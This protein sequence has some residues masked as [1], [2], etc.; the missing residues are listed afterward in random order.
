[1]GEVLGHAAVAEKGEPPAGESTKHA[2]GRRR[3][4]LS[5]CGVLT[6]RPVPQLPPRQ[7]AIARASNASGVANRA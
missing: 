6:V 2:A 1:M 7:R 4:R 3:R 5:V